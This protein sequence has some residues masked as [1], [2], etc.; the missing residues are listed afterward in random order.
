MVAS[1]INFSGGSLFQTRIQACKKPKRNE[2]NLLKVLVANFQSYYLLLEL[3][4]KCYLSHFQHC[5]ETWAYSGTVM[6]YI[7]FSSLYSMSQFRVWLH[8]FFEKAK[9]R[10]SF[11][12]DSR[13]NLNNKLLLLHCKQRLKWNF[14]LCRSVDRYDT[15]PDGQGTFYSGHK[16]TIVMWPGECLCDNWKPSLLHLL[17]FDWRTFSRRVTARW[18]KSVD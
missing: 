2:Q 16:I 18:W 17:I 13:C 10:S 6:V 9:F 7:N 12:W 11:Y 1:K 4:L 14:C 15:N 5:L 8:L 3:F